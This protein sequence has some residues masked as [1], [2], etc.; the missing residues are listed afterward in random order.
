MK[1][2]LVFGI[3]FSIISAVFGGLVLTKAEESALKSVTKKCT[4]AL[5]GDNVKDKIYDLFLR[6]R[7]EDTGLFGGPNERQKSEHIRVTSING[8]TAKYQTYVINMKKN[9]DGSYKISKVGVRILPSKGV[10]SVECIYT[11][12][13]MPKGSTTQSRVPNNSKKPTTIA[14]KPIKKPSYSIG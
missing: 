8:V 2:L 5:V 12:G 3:L 6:T 11:G 1:K 4:V 7:D 10:N 14:K 9:E 13:K